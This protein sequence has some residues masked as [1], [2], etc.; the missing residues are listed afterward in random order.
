MTSVFLSH[1]SDDKPFLRQLKQDLELNG[2]QVWI[3]EEQLGIGERLGA[4]LSD[5]IENND[6]VVLAISASS[7]ASAWVRSEAVAAL[8]ENKLLPILVPAAESDRESTDEATQERIFRD[9]LSVLQAAAAAKQNEPTSPEQRTWA[10]FRG[11]RYRAALER[12]VTTIVRREE[13]KREEGRGQNDAR[14]RLH[15]IGRGSLAK[16]IRHQLR[17]QSGVLSPLV[18]KAGSGKSHLLRQISEDEAWAAYLDLEPFGGDPEKLARAVDH[19]FVPVLLL[20]KPGDFLRRS[21][22]Y[23]CCEELVARGKRVAVALQ[24]GD[25]PGFQRRLEDSP[26]GVGE[27]FFLQD[28]SLRSAVKLAVGLTEDCGTEAPDLDE[29]ALLRLLETEFPQSERTPRWPASAVHWLT[30]MHGRDA[31]ATTHL[32]DHFRHERHAYCE[33]VLASLDCDQRRVI[34]EIGHLAESYVPRPEDLDRLELLERCGL[35][36]ACTNSGCWSILD[37]LLARHFAEPLVIHHMSDLHF[38]EDPREQYAE[39]YL[40]EIASSDTRR[41]HLLVLSG[42]MREPGS[43]GAP[44]DAGASERWHAHAT[45][46]L[47]DVGHELRKRPHALLDGDAPRVLLVPGN[48]DVDWNEKLDSPLLSRPF[49]QVC[50]AVHP[51]VAWPEP[52]DDGLRVQT[53][54]DS[55]DGGRKVQLLLLDSTA[56]G[57]ARE[58]NVHLWDWLEAER[59]NGRREALMSS[60]PGY[61][62]PE[63]L[64]KVDAVSDDPRLVRIG[65]LHHPVSPV[66]C[67]WVGRFAGLLNAGQLK[68]RLISKRTAAVLHGHMHASWLGRESW[69]LESSW[70]L[71]VLGAPALGS[72][73]LHENPGFNEV[74]VIYEGDEPLVMLRRF[75]HRGSSWMRGGEFLELFTP[76][77]ESDA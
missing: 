20:D 34:R 61:V 64:L 40:R 44:G 33:A 71:R 32:D 22:F 76:G 13:S 46:W 49:R 48:H 51:P 36:A 70:S 43:D 19:I 45:R 8:T 66:P 27:P 42:D 18:G 2:L 37:P 77:E 38:G 14:S 23:R 16:R 63:T 67:R 73:R 65:V 72:E 47:S 58:L 75:W 56:F 39:H 5:A 74:R 25:V 35:I 68:E 41:P 69:P 26:R 53:F 50:E 24:P 29:E 11:S 9:F 57:A 52:G 15:R 6:Y 30:A 60:E 10:D 4:R 31:K 3:D 21:E 7:Y 59:A 55:E 62:A 54:S 28:L 12:L 17:P 1:S